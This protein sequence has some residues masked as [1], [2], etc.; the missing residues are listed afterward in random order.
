MED[1]NALEMLREY[2]V[3]TVARIIREKELKNTA[4]FMASLPELKNLCVSEFTECLRNL[5]REEI[6]VCHPDI[7][8]NVMFEFKPPKK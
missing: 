2:A 3:D 6:L 8:K 4:P 1:N 5:V 7:N